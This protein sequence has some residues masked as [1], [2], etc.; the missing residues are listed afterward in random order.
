MTPQN[1]IELS[2]EGDFLITFPTDIGKHKRAG[3]ITGAKYDKLTK[4][5]VAPKNYLLAVIDT[6]PGFARSGEVQD[7]V[8]TYTRGEIDSKNKI[9]SSVFGV[10]IGI[11]N[12]RT[13]F[14]HQIEGVYAILKQKRLVLAHEMGLGKTTTALVAGKYSGLPIWVVAPRNLHTAWS[15]EAK[16]LD[17]PIKYLISW[18]KIPKAP[19]E[20][21]FC[22]L[23]EAQALQTFSTRRTQTALNF[24]NKARYVVCITG[25]PAKNGKP[26]NMFGLLSA[27]KHPESYRKAAYDKAYRGAS[28]L[29]ALYAATKDVVL[30]R[31]KEDCIDLP[32]KLRTLRIAALSDEART[33]YD[34]IFE[35]LRN[36]WAERVKSNLITSSNEKLVIFMQ[37]RHAASWAKL[38]A[39]EEVAEELNDNKKQAVFFVSFT[40]TADSLTNAISKFAT[41]GKITGDV[42]QT[43]RQKAIDTFQDGNTRFIV[44]T[45]G[46]GGLGIT[47]NAAHHVI[48]VD[49]PWT[50]SDCIQAE[51]RCHRI[52]QKNAVLVDWIQCGRVDERIDSLLLNKQQNISTILTGNKEELQLSFDIRSDMDDLL[53]GIFL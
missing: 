33:T 4:C 49:R 43:S 38:H 2:P 26:S 51:D 47:L 42:T 46:A 44:A 13:L 10:G 14:R 34:K 17:I 29:P 30:F 39:A 52:G 24:C 31:K 9:A 6:F 1:R 48:L 22:I 25:T 21:F 11:I 45:F 19:D 16:I 41:V 12:G 23:D 37:L 53:R 20:N 35:E 8:N 32:E 28:N 3:E 7:I 50:S 18:A 40:D 5:W 36:K 15:R 27:I